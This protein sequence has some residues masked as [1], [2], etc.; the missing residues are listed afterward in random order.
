MYKAK[1]G[2]ENTDPSTELYNFSKTALQLYFKKLKNIR[3]KCGSNIF[4][5]LIYSSVTNGL[6]NFEKI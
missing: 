4:S 1:D 3:L 5:L 6:Q 2:E